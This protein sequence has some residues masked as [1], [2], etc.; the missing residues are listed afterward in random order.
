MWFWIREI[1]TKKAIEPVGTL[2][3]AA[4]EVLANKLYDS[5]KIDI[6]SLGVTL[7]YL[8]NNTSGFNKATEGDTFYSLIKNENFDN[9]WDELSNNGKGIGLS[10]EFKN[11]YIKMVS[12][13][14]KNRP[15]IDEILNSE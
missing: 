1:K 3:Y 13:N 11:I 5:S 14:P 15:S 8:V 12:F 6:F 9:Y 10:N 2:R 7:F 4:P